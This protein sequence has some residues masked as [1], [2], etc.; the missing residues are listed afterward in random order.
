MYM[1][2]GMNNIFIDMSI[3]LSTRGPAREQLGRYDPN[4]VHRNGNFQPPCMY[5]P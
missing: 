2:G 5:T 4:K 1:W 3:L